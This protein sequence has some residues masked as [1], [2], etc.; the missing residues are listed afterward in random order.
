MKTTKEDEIMQG[1]ILNLE[2]YFMFNLTI[3][4]LAEP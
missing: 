3:V 4:D 2:A 1:S